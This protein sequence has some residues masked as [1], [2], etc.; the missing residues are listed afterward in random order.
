MGAYEL[1]RGPMGAYVLLC[2]PMSAFVSLGNPMNVHRIP[3]Y[4]IRN[5]II[6]D[7]VLTRGFFLIEDPH[8]VYYCMWLYQ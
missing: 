7:K 4:N 5:N 8:L 3:L 6:R 2:V 1:L